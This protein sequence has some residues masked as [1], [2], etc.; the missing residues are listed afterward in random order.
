MKVKIFSHRSDPD[1][2]GSPILT[3][4]IYGGGVTDITL[5]SG[6]EELDGKLDTFINTKEYEQFDYIFITDLCP[7]LHY[8]E[9]IDKNTLLKNKLL[10]FDHHESS[11]AKLEKEYT[12]LTETEDKNGEKCCG[13]SLFYEYLM[14]NNKLLEKEAIKRFVELTRLHD[15]YEWKAKNILDA[16]Y[17]QILFQFLGPYGYLYHFVEKMGHANEFQYTEKE[18]EWIKEQIEKNQDKIV[19]IAK[20]I[21]IIN[22]EN[23]KYALTLANYEYR[24]LLADYIKEN[25]SEI[26]AL[27]LIAG[28]ENRFS[29]RSIQPDVSVLEVAETC[30]GGG[31]AKAAGG[32]LNEETL[33]KIL[34]FIK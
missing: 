10:I 22:K 19:E 6:I 26:D 13:T 31:H 7:S 11:M 32:K 20:N 30:G 27:L 4:L 33:Q 9:A 25:M 1:G 18:N 23:I 28:N 3:I 24:N 5:C 12:F 8:L 2:L 21:V 29:F 15:T 16:Y 34:K 17:L 14:Q